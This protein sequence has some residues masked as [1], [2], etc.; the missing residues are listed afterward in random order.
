[1]KHPR[2]LSTFSR[3]S[4]RTLI[5]A[6]ALCV[7]AAGCAQEVGEIDRTQPNRLQS[8]VF[9][10][11]W[12]LGRTVID[13]P[14]TT[15]FTFIGESAELERIRWD[16]QEELLIAYRVYDRVDGTDKSVQYSEAPYQGAP[17]VAFQIK[18]H[19][20][21]QREYNS[22]TGEES[23][24]LV[25]NDSDRPWYERD[26]VRVDWS[27]NVLPSLTFLV[28][29]YGPN[30]VVEA[31]LSY[32]VDDPDDPH[33]TVAGVRT[34]D[35]WTDYSDWSTIGTLASADYLEATV[36]VAVQ[37]EQIQIEDWYGNVY[38]DPACWYYLD[39]D[40]EHQPVTIRLSF[41]KVEE[42]TG[43]VPLDYPDNEIARARSGRTGCST[44]DVR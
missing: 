15:T 7:C 31:P 2:R 4:W 1:V 37:P 30:Y 32:Q 35:G 14:Y 39:S 27:K 8:S 18:K 13:V 26:Y 43:Y 22:A 29:W 23:N 5:G 24:V 28:N 21:I 11:D 20:D 36:K 34:E 33:H 25:E 44:A 9:E 12:Y 38:Q 3:L 42:D 17:I 6:W 19:F 16:V 41:L 40:C 10:G